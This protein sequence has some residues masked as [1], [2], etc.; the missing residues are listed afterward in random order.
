MGRGR[1]FYIDLE[2]C[3]ELE[4]KPNLDS[5][6]SEGGEVVEKEGKLC[7]EREAAASFISRT[8]VYFGEEVNRAKGS[9]HLSLMV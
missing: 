5:S 4:R 6:T 8:R 3:Q 7:K 9:A 1:V 2:F